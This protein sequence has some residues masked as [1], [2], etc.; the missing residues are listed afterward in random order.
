MAGKT[1]RKKTVSRAGGVTTTKITRRSGTTVTKKK[2]RNI[3]VKEV[4]KSSGKSRVKGTITAK[5]P[6]TKKM[7][8]YKVN[9]KGTKASKPK[10]KVR[11]SGG[12]PKKSGGQFS[13]KRVVAKGRAKKK[14]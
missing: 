2:G 11:V 3:N 10:S 13:R 14:K 9:T 6:G 1:K 8:T 5:D 12:K 4:T 7:T